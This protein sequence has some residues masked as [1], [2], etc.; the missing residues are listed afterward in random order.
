MVQQPLEHQEHRVYS[1]HT[2]VLQAVALE[3][4]MVGEAIRAR[5][6]VPVERAR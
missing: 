2:L 4:Q 3:L 5:M 6:E 1:V